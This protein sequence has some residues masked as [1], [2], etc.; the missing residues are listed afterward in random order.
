VFAGFVRL[1]ELE[2]IGFFGLLGS[3]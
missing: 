2:F 3:F 1:S